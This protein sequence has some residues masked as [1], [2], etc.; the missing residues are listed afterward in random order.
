[1]S[2]SIEIPK[3]DNIET[4]VEKIK[5]KEL[6][7]LDLV[8]EHLERAKLV[9]EK[10]NSFITILED[11]ALANAKELDLQIEKGEVDIESKPLLGIPFTAKDLYLVKDTK[12][13]FGTKLM[14]NFVAP[15]TSTV[16]QKC[17]DAGAILIA[18][19]NLDPFGYGSS[20]ESSGYGPTK[21]P[22]DL[23]RVPGGSSSG[24]GAS[25]AAGVGL[26]SLG[27]DTGGSVRLPASFCGVYALKPTYGHNSRYGVG[28]YASS[29]DTPGFFSRHPE[30]IKLLEDVMKGRDENDATTYE[31]DHLEIKNNKTIGL[32]REF[33]TE[34][35]NPEIKDKINQKVE[36]LKSNG[37]EIKEISIPSLK[38]A[39]AAYYVLVMAETSSN[40]ARYDAVRYG[41]KISDDY[42]ENMSGGRA[43]F[44]EDEVK[45]RIMV[46]TYVL[47]AGYGDQ[48]YQ[49]ASIVR[50]KLKKEFDEAFKEVDV[51]ISP[52][53]NETA[54]KIEEKSSDP[55]SMY[56]TDIYTVTANVVGIPALAIPAGMS[57]EGLPIG[58]QLIGKKFHED[59]L[60]DVA[61]V[62]R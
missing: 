29:F 21:N 15:Y 58:M 22:Y 27:T 5:S 28:V 18:K 20:G 1:M 33:F 57:L 51:I 41:E 55:V 7:V 16:V 11:Q 44:F 19:A 32:P 26:F 48:Y 30:D 3:I 6:K 54:F 17:L 52:I 14:E 12:T 43:Q 34:D 56:L 38:Y 39:L 42:E 46:G 23:E 60:V 45:R 25:I 24:S 61:K 13:T 8:I 40:R 37:Y 50:T 49:K 53:A 2:N 31:I 47:S 4:I 36:L 62:V 9:Q 10:T 35:L 59:Q